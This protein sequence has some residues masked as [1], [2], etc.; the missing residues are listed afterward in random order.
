ML[1][2]SIEVINILGQVFCTDKWIGTIQTI[3]D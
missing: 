2:E 3:D 1:C